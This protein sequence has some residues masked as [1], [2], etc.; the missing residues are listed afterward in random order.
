MRVGYLTS[1]YPASSHTFIRREIEAVRACG[2]E[3]CTFSVRAPREDERRAATDQ[4]AFDQTFYILPVRAA[5]LVAT[6]AAAFARRP[7][8]YLRTLGLALRHRVPGAKAWVWAV[9]YFV[10]AIVLARELERQ[11]VEHL[12]NHFANAGATVG[13]LASSYLGLPWS[14]ML[15]GI[16]ELDYPAGLLLGRKLQAARFAAC[17]SH[18]VR[19]QAM[20]LSAPEDWHKLFIVRCALDL[21]VL[22]TLEPKATLN[23][24]RELVRVICVGR[25]SEEKAHLG[26]LEAFQRA[27]ERG[28]AVELVLIGDGPERARI[29]RRIA[30]LGLQGAVALRGRLPEAET[31]TEVASSDILV[32]SSLMEGLPVVLM[33][34]MALRVP[35]IAPCVA[36][37]PELVE[38][39]V[40]GLL[41]APS[42]W[43][44]LADRLQTLAGDRGLRERLG[45]AGR[46][47][48]EAE[49]EISKAVAPL[50]ARWRGE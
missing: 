49:F 18:F 4:A 37:V 24:P 3:V 5:A 41:F 26:L 28:A 16:S 14:L 36:G 35:V 15:H 23:N 43:S 10:E 44:E 32:L 45:A 50:V 1:Q 29:E 25:L 30:E 21:E 42:A 13:L 7:G 27:R 39:N 20:R 40:H 47:K 12:H 31:L 6:H 33:E 2:L 46:A 34:A 11:R 19:A 17:A 48:V 22:P 8:A 38:D 9:F